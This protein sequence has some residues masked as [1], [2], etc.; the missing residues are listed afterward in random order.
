M[1]TASVGGTLSDLPEGT[2]DV[3]R[4]VAEHILRD[5]YVSL[6]EAAE[7]LGRKHTGRALDKLMTNLPL[8]AIAAS[9]KQGW[10]LIPKGEEQYASIYAL[11]RRVGKAEVPRDMT[12]NDFS[13]LTAFASP[14]EKLLLRYM[15]AKTYG[16]EQAAA[17]FSLHRGTLKTDL[18]RVADALDAVAAEDAAAAESGGSPSRYKRQKAFHKALQQKQRGGRQPWEENDNGSAKALTLAIAEE[19]VHI[20]LSL[21]PSLRPI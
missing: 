17:N 12:E 21:S 18:Q 2:E 3:Y 10:L 19:A 13:A 9:R 8:V 20:S 14:A 11:I 4:K 15:L 7:M 16:I 1:T 6:T 5:G